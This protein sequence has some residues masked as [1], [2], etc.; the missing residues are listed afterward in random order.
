MAILQFWFQGQKDL[1]HLKTLKIQ[2]SLSGFK[3]QGKLQR[4]TMAAWVSPRCRRVGNGRKPEKNWTFF[5][6]ITMM[7][8]G[9]KRG[10]V[11]QHLDDLRIE[12]DRV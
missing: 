1:K 11:C 2:T 5:G 7:N 12:M 10:N 8:W 4:W 9:P 3:N 6:T